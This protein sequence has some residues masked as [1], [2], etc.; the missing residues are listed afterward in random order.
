MQNYLIGGVGWETAVWREARHR[1]DA[2]CV[3]D[4]RR[5]RSLSRG[6]TATSASGRTIWI[7]ANVSKLFAIR[8]HAEAV[9]WLQLALARERYFAAGL[10][11]RQIII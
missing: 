5:W 2:P 11:R 4:V 3:R 10:T 9:V 8:P 1:I 6:Q 7:K